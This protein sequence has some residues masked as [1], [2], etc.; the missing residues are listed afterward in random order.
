MTSVKTAFSFPMASLAGPAFAGDA[1][2]NRAA[3]RIA[4][5]LAK[6]CIVASRVIEL[7]RYFEPDQRLAE[8]NRAAGRSADRS[9]STI[10]P[11]QKIIAR[12]NAVPNCKAAMTYAKSCLLGAAHVPL[13]IESTCQFGCGSG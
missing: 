1:R 9:F 6:R 12:T 2:S 7:P 3:M 10:G 13:L 5:L 4:S 8:R 11:A